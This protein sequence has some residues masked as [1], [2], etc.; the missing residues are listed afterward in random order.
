MRAVARALEEEEVL[1]AGFAGAV[2]R[3]EVNAGTKGDWRAMHD[4][5]FI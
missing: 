4:G 5:S 3:V 1:E 2:G